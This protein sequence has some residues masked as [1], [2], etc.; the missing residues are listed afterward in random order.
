MLLVLL[1][2][3]TVAAGADVD[4]FHK[5][6][7]EAEKVA[8]AEGK[9]LYLHFT[10]TWCGWCRRIENDV[11][12]KPEGKKALAGFVCASLDCTV[13]R[14]E[15]ATGTTK[16]NIDLMRKNGG[17][18]YPF[19][20]MLTPDG[21]RLHTIGGYKPL[22]AFQ[23]EIATAEA[24][25]GKYKAFQTYAA[26]ADKT[27]YEY[28]AKALDF[29]S[30]TSA[31]AKAAEAAAALKKLDPQFKKGKAALA[32][33]AVLQGARL[34]KADAARIAALEDE[35]I[36]H[37]PTNAAGY[38]EKVLWG[39]AARLARTAQSQGGAAKQQATQQAI[40]ALDLLLKKAEK[41]S[42][43]ANTHGYIG[44]LN[45]RAGRLDEALAA[46]N[47]ALELEGNGPGAKRYKAY[48][49]MFQKAKAKAQK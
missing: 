39:R 24:N 23:K 44:F 40:A 9:P 1:A 6:Y 45:F 41:L 37:D 32:S 19:L 16:F 11:Y 3:A 2:A 34:S 18:G 33:F 48:I 31:W 43:R 35:A 22:P 5:T 7:A 8:K 27:T 38:L 49:D 14:G 30:E 36:A 10:T 26:Q 42:N 29:Y 4:Y 47:K 28:N 46:M 25:Y 20:L 12:K 13:P 17:G 21:V 15:Q